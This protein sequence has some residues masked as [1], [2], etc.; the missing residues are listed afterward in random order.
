MHALFCHNVR[1]RNRTLSFVNSIWVT[2][3]TW[4]QIKLVFG[5]VK[6]S[7]V[8]KF[9]TPEYDFM[10]FA[11]NLGSPHLATTFNFKDTK[12]GPLPLLSPFNHN[13]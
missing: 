2:I 1:A 7:L 13:L 5:G 8:F 10:A 3:G 11:N 4:S 6:E 9:S 12:F